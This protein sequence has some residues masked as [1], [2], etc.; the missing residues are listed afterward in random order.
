M[1]RFAR[2]QLQ[3]VPGGPRGL[4]DFLGGKDFAAGLSLGCLEVRF[5]LNTKLN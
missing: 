1:A 2:Q 4:E 5:L 3:A